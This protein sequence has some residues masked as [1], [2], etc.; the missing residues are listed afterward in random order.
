MKKGIISKMFAVLL[1]FG[2]LFSVLPTQQAAAQDLITVC[3]SGCK[4]TTIQ[5]AIGNVVD[6]DEII[7]ET[8][9]YNEDLTINKKVTLKSTTGANNVIVIGN[10]S[11][12]SPDVTIDG[13]TFEGK[14]VLKASASGF[15]FKNNI[16]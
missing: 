9:T 7:V 12:E 13:F 6:G 2:M 8:G 14:I 4:Y 11:I 16:V 15:I 3:A 10:G 1:V 5:T